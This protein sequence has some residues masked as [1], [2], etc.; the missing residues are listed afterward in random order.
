LRDPQSGPPGWKRLWRH[1]YAIGLRWLFREARHG[2]PARRIG[3][4]RLVVPL[5]PRRYYELGRVAD[6]DFSGTCLD[7]SSPKLLPSLLQSER[8]GT[9]TC[10]DLFADEI[11]AWRTI[12]PALDLRVEDA[13]SLSFADE[14]FDH[15]VCISVIE[16]IGGGRDVDALAEIW[17]VLKPSGTLHLTTDVAPEPSDVFV[18][19]RVYG[20]ASNVVDERGVFFKHEYAPAELDRLIATRPWDIV[21][22]EFAALRNPRVE[23]AFNEHAPWTYPLG[24]FLRLVCPSN[25]ERSRDPGVLARAG[26]GTAYV[27]LRKTHGVSL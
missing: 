12:D 10:V 4:V 24:P 11:T 8:R 1:S 20:D 23:R 21:E 27:Q 9:W 16:H 6:A 22:R 26:E 2:W 18:D 3:F 13:T 19:T 17:R 15:C 14:M 7:V 5:D 25:F